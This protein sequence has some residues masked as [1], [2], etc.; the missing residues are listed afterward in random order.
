MKVLILILSTFQLFT[1]QSCGEEVKDNV[2]S[3]LNVGYIECLENRLPCECERLTETY[4]S[5][6][7]DT[8]SKS[9]NYGVALLKFNQMEPY[10]YPIKRI[11]SN[12]YAV[13]KSKKDSTSWGSI[14]MKKDSLYFTYDN[15]LSKFFNSKN[16]NAYDWKSYMAGNVTLLNRSFV[17]RGYPKLEEITKQDSLLCNCN[18]WMGNVDLLYVKGKSQSWILEI[19][20]DSLHIDVIINADRDPDDPVHTEKLISYKWY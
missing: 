19:K 4:Y 8:I 17:K 9:K 2:Y 5:I 18:K 7:V 20:N 12:K 13:L 3:W 6:V 16:A 10:I 14:I 15:I 11:D 1:L